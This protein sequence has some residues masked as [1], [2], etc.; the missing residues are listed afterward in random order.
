MSPAGPR[1]LGGELLFQLLCTG[2]GVLF[3]GLLTPASL[4]FLLATADPV[5]VPC[6]EADMHPH[7]LSYR[8]TG[9]APDLSD[10]AIERGMGLPTAVFVPLRGVGSTRPAAVVIRTTDPSV[11]EWARDPAQEPGPGVHAWA[12]R[13]NYNG[14]RVAISSSGDDISNREIASQLRGEASPF[15]VLEEDGSLWSWWL[16]VGAFAICLLLSI[17]AF[18]WV[19]RRVRKRSRAA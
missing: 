6:E 10:F 1:R 11:L 14:A 15:I 19:L 9:C 13:G 8:L 5:T 4:V 16:F 12:R 17:V 2:G 3:F 7:A 18:A